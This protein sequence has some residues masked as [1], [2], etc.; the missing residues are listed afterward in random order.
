MAAVTSESG[1]FTLAYSLAFH[2]RAESLGVCIF[3]VNRVYFES[4]AVSPCAHLQEFTCI[5]LLFFSPLSFLVRDVLIFVF[6]IQLLYGVATVCSVIAVCENA[7]CRLKY[8]L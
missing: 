4:V 6:S 2:S 1:F 8:F 3:L 5:T 7:L